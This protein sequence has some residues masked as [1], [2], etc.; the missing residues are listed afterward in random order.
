MAT[1]ES[2]TVKRRRL[3]MLLRRFRADA[4]ISGDNVAK[5]MER[6]E[7]WI[8]RLER[9]RTGIRRHDLDRLLD[10]YQVGPDVRTEL[11][12]LARGGRERGWWSKYSGVLSKQYSSYIGFEAEASRLLIYESLVV[13]GLLQTEDYARALLRAGAPEESMGVVDRKVEVRL[14]RQ[15]RLTDENPLSLWVVLDEAV[16]RRVIGGNLPAHLGQLDRL[17]DVA[18]N[19]ST[20]RIQAV[21]FRDSS[22]PG[23]LSSFT[24]VNFP[25]DPEMVY[26]EGLTGDLYEDP[27]E[28]ER[29]RVVFDNLRAAALSDTSTIELIKRVRAELAA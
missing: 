12:E 15:K 17:I 14:S 23:M 24:I 16:L 5:H 18:E 19:S 7:S 22:H 21:P 3:G 6:N 27:P 29:Y 20:I 8:S 13:H 25:G 28:S 26:I 10:L 2:P 1:G 4:D 11:G 9:G